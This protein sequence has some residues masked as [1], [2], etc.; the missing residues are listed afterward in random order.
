MKRPSLSDVRIHTFAN[1]WRPT[2]RSIP[3]RAPLGAAALAV[4]VLVQHR[5]THPS[6][7]AGSFIVRAQLVAT[8]AAAAAATTL[9][10]PAA[11]L[12]E[13]SPTT[14]GWR[15]ALRLSNG[16]AV[17]ASTWALALALIAAAP[18]RTPVAELTLQAGALLAVA[19]GAAATW[20]P[21]AGSAAVA[22]VAF[23]A[24][25]VPD[26]W[27]LLGGGP[28][29]NGR[30]GLLA[31]AGVAAFAWAMRDQAR[32]TA[33]FRRLWIWS[34]KPD[35]PKPDRSLGMSPAIGGPDVCMREGNASRTRS[36][37]GASTAAVE[38]HEDGPD[39]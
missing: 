8:A 39:V 38:T 7:D 21:A 25:L 18:G 4:V 14:A 24:L 33:R 13:T 31:I 22:L 16:L 10:D 20:G 23:S 37:R 26:R 2:G 6:A 34:G 32:R 19:V 36:A 29:A 17:W 27:S 3:W 15:A 1:A 30:L 9:E 28:D 5:V 12:V 11:A 35:D